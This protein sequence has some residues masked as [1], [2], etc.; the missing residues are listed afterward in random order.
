MPVHFKVKAYCCV[1][2]IMFPCICILVYVV[3]VQKHQFNK[4]AQNIKHPSR[5][6]HEISISLTTFEI[7]QNIENIASN[8]I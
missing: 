7:H 3:Q 5:F 4:V 1:Q 8:E 2:T 6:N